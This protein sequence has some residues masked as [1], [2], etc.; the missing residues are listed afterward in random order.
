MNENNLTIGSL[1]FEGIDF[2]SWEDL[3]LVTACETSIKDAKKVEL[4]HEDHIFVN[5]NI[6][7][8]YIKGEMLTPDEDSL[9]SIDDMLASSDS[10]TVSLGLDLLIN[11]N[12]KDNR[13]RVVNV[14]KR[15]M[16]NVISNK[17]T[18]SVGFKNVLTQLDL[19]LTKLNSY[20]RIRLLNHC[21][22]KAINGQDKE[23][24]R[25]GIIEETETRIREMLE[26]LN[27]DNI[28]NL[29]CEINIS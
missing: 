12:V 15:N 22:I 9:S 5:I 26:R 25:K 14:L 20:S 18:I 27:P 11:Y 3:G 1:K 24:A 6:L 28:Y 2:S 7:E 10:E 29:T 19:S 8:N 23:E 13:T 17:R 16:K 21:Y 4:L